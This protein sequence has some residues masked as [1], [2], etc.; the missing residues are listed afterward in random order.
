MH[1]NHNRINSSFRIGDFLGGRKAI[2]LSSILFSLSSALLGA[3]DTYWGFTM[4]SFTAGIFALSSHTLAFVY[5]SE[6]VG[7]NY[8]HLTPGVEVFRIAG[9]CLYGLVAYTSQNWR[10]LWWYGAF[11]NAFLLPIWVILHESPR[12][13]LS[14]GHYDEFQ[15][16][17]TVAAKCNGVQL[18]PGSLERVVERSRIVNVKI[19]EDEAKG[20][21][22]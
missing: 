14:R 16:V 9:S 6:V 12:W 7:K 21:Y 5:L 1:P 20:L 2:I 8:V 22:R 17:M 13:L 10:V 4:L 11:M 19:G 18:N 3:T 15:R